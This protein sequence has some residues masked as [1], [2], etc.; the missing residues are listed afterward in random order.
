M[1]PDY[2]AELDARL[3]ALDML[4]SACLQRAFTLDYLEGM[5][6]TAAELEH[7]RSVAIP[8]PDLAPAR[9]F[10][11]YDRILRDAIRLAKS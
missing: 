3:Q 2:E 9:V 5:Q 11:H 4:M 8:M 6:K 10:K 7:Q 1:S